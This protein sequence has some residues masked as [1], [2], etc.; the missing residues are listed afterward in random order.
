M[1][2][3][4]GLL[5]STG[6]NPELDDLLE[7]LGNRLQAGERLDLEAV[8]AEHPQ[9]ADDL[10]RYFPA[11]QVLAG[12]R[13][14]DSRPLSEK[15]NSV[16]DYEILEE[17][18]RGGM[19][20]VY[21]AR[22]RSLDR[23]VALKM[24]RAGELATP[25]DLQRFRNEAKIVA[26]LDHP[27]IVPIYEVGEQDQRLYYTMK[28]IDGGSLMASLPS[29][30]TNPRAAAELV[31]DIAQAVHHAHE[32]GILHCDLK[33]SNILLDKD[34]RPNISDFGLAR[35]L[36]TDGS[37]SESGVVVGTPSYMSPEQAAG[38]Y[39]ETSPLSDVYGLGAILYALLTGRP[40]FQGMTTLE[41]LD[42]VRTLEPVPP[43]RLEAHVPRP[44]EAVCLKC[45]HKEPRLRYASARALAEDLQRYLA[46]LP[47]N[48]RSAGLAARAWLWCRRPERIRDAGVMMVCFNATFCVW[49]LLGLLAVTL[50]FLR[51][52]R[53]SAAGWNLALPVV[54][55]YA[56]AVWLGVK[57][58]QRRFWAVW[59]GVLFTLLV[60]L[61]IGLLYHGQP[62]DMGGLYTEGDPAM[63]FAFR[64]LD[65]LLMTVQF[66]AMVLALL[67]Y[68]ANRQSLAWSRPSSRPVSE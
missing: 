50:G 31:A 56:P 23:R 28:L 12:L 44:L 6:T 66:L 39:R 5:V 67:V 49:G 2:G 68:Y 35:W 59:A 7:E 9:H 33:P 3:Q 8:V 58:I 18:G 47:T 19:G 38:R 55:L 26:N 65:L 32:Q 45:L 64:T 54:C 43:T 46:G 29:F 25:A 1:S 16:G 14:T 10:R 22:H 57:V 48:A 60:L 40:P 42:Q 52:D 51:S 27:R 30:Q 34:G 20:V 61:V 62:H 53:P 15:T 13:E 63:A 24:L 37:L 21:K 41:T 36:E 11:L 4:S 17:I